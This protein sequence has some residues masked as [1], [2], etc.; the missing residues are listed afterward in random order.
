MS[1]VVCT[2]TAV[3][4]GRVVLVV[5]GGEVLVVVGA[6]VLGTLV[7]VVV[8]VVVGPVTVVVLVVLVVVECVV[9]VG[10]V[11]LVTCVVLVVDVVVLVVATP[12]EVVVVL[13]GLVVVEPEHGPVRVGG[14]LSGS[15]GSV[16]QS[17]SRR[18]KTPSSSRSTPMRVA[19][20]RRHAGEGELLA[21]GRGQVP[22]RGRGLRR[23]R[24]AVELEVVA[25]DVHRAARLA[26][27]VA[28]HDQVAAAGVGRATSRLMR[29][30]NAVVLNV[31]ASIDTCWPT[32]G[33]SPVSKA[34]RNCSMLLLVGGV[35]VLED[36]RR[37]EVEHGRDAAVVQEA[38]AAHLIATVAPPATPNMPTF[39]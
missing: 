11:V 29:F 16:P 14:K 25:A 18:S 21:G 30:T 17:S 19:D 26:G 20:S 1:D 5:G 23:V 38:E 37:D 31:V 22:H 28:L 39:W 12:V 6:S 7:L 32:A 24:V 2:S 4:V 36:R 15:A 27:D 9:V 35:Q 13:E 3:E 34:R 33:L 10:T 8:L